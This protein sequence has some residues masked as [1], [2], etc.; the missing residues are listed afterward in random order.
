[1]NQRAIYDL[2][3]HFWFEL[4]HLGG[5]AEIRPVPRGGDGGF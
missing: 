2:R 1:M 4:H 5:H 3:V